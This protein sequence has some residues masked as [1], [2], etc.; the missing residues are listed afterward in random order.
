MDASPSVKPATSGWSASHLT[1]REARKAIE[2]S[3]SDTGIRIPQDKQKLIF[4]A[5]Q[6]ADGTTS[7]KYGG[8]GLGL[9]ISREIA[10]LLGGEL[11][12]RSV[13]GEGLTFTLFVPLEPAG[14][15][16]S[17][18]ETATTS[19]RTMA[20]VAAPMPLP[21][22]RANLGGKNRAEQKLR[23]ENYR[24]EL[25][26]LR[27]V[28]ELE[29]SRA[30]QAAILDAL[31]IALFEGVV[32]PEG[33]VRRRFVGG[34]L[35]QL[36]GFAATVDEDA[37]HEWESNIHPE[38]RERASRND[39][40][41]QTVTLHHRWTSNDGE[42]RHFFEQC[43]RVDDS[44]EGQERWAGTLLDVTTRKRLEEQRVQAGK[45]EAIGQ[46]TGGV[47]HD[48]NNLLTAVLGGIHVHERRLTLGERK[49]LID[50]ILP[51]T[52]QP[53]GPRAKR[54]PTPAPASVR[55]I[56]LVDDDE[57]VRTVVGEQL[58]EHGFDVVATADGASAIRA[59]D[60]GGEFD[61]L[62]SDFAMAG[63]NGVQTINRIIS[64]RP[65][66]R[67]ALMTGYADDRL[68]A[69]DREAM[70]VF[71]KPIDIDELLGFVAS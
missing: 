20:A 25:E 62:L 13:P 10:R 29:Q 35:M 8:T 70:T 58:R 66:M 57:A 23:D 54:A 15:R 6:Q 18:P 19:A 32:G 55:S 63:F 39:S 51:S 50:T 30:Q 40:G 37:H 17:L 34:N 7:R 38:D 52:P 41:S 61:F 71:R 2:I 22:D 11:Q 68:T 46:L 69:I 27:I 67:S 53:V 64:M 33:T 47:A 24:A 49:Q 14:R 9:S 26:R 3:V 28:R 12:V 5:F 48:F 21:D 59:V 1:L 56:L 60:E 42:V 4:E 43:V 31:P 44:G 45:M 36:A 65:D 16:I